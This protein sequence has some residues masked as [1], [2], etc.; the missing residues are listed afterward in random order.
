MDKSLESP[1]IL[2]LQLL[3]SLLRLTLLR[4]FGYKVLVH[5]PKEALE[6]DV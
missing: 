3:S 1:T 2:W 4:V 5:V 6:Y